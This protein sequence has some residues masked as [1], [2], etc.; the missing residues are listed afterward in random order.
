MKKYT[1]IGPETAN[2]LA[3]IFFTDTENEPYISVSMKLVDP[4]IHNNA[5]VSISI[6][7]IEICP[8]KSN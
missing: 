6:S 4:F 1:T 5:G 3:C 2:S 8:Y 7:S